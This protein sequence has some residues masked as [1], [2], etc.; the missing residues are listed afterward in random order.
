MTPQ[1]KYTANNREK[2]R[3]QYK[4][5][6]D[7]QKGRWAEWNKHLRRKYKIDAVEYAF[8]LNAQDCSCKIC[9]AHQST[10]RDETLVV[11]HCHST[12]KVRGLLC[13]KCNAGHGQY[14]D[15]L[16]IMCDS[17]VYVAEHRNIFDL[18]KEST[19]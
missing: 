4:R 10:T 9:G 14:D 2:V 17:A 15:N 16:T 13:H 7:S 5:Y 12:G 18:I 19:L 8:M 3:E 1:Q 11:D 6:R